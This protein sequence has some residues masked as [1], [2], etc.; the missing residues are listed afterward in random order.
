[1]GSPEGAFA[2]QGRVPVEAAGDAVDPCHLECLLEVERREQ[3]REA[4]RQERLAGSGRSQKKQPVTSGS[5]DLEGALGPRLAPDVAQ[6]HPEGQVGWRSRG[7]D[8]RGG[9]QL[10]PSA[11]G[12]H[13]RSQIVCDPD[14]DAGSQA[15]LRSV[16]PGNDYLLDPRRS[17][18]K[19]SRQGAPHGAEPAVQGQLSHQGE[20]R[21]AVVLQSLGGG[22]DPDRNGEIQASAALSNPRGGQIHRDPARW[23]GPADR[24]YGGSDA[25]CAL[26]DSSLRKTDD[27]DPRKLGADPNLHLDRDA[28][29]T[30]EGGPQDTRHGDLRGTEAT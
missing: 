23:N 9:R 25:G 2:D 6:I 30:G 3:S 20:A 17:Q 11:E 10:L 7:G 4:A 14:I 12:F 21:Q 13:H 16:L 27:V 18:A 29:D 22:E 1:M 28:V 24:R 5:H 26:S 19:G 15:R 8:L